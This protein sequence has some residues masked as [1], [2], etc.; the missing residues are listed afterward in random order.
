[1]GAVT[2]EADLAA[3]AADEAIRNIEE[4]EAEAE[5]AAEEAAVAAAAVA[6]AV[7]AAAVAA[8]AVAGAPACLVEV[9]PPCWARG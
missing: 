2:E 9:R 8:A 1:M 3:A 6:A 5:A 4:A 7:E